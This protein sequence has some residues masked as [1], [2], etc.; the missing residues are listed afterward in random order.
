MSAVEPAC[1]VVVMA[2]VPVPGLAKTRLIP[3]LGAAGAAGLAGRL[4]DH[5]LATA[6]AAGIGPVT[7]ACAP[8]V[9]HPF[10]IACATRH[11]VDRIAQDTGDLGARMHAAI[12]RGG[13]SA[14]ATL[15]MGS[16]C[17]ALTPADL[18]AAAAHLRNGADVVLAPAED[19]GYAL[20]GMT[21][22]HAALFADVPWGSDGVLA[23]T[24][25]RIRSLGLRAA[26]LRTVWDVDRPEDYERLV[27]SALLVG[28][29][30]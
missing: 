12:V 15:V 14:A 2:K 26:E 10:F 3:L 8:D 5:A 9:D 6:R 11:A 4:L 16:D 1:R 28:P 21:R 23:A 30:H 25:D 20:I 13:A 19:G 22:P 18:R 7:F 17:P 24:R 27:R 29:R